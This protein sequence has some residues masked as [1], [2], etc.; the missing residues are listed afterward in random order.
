MKL[1]IIGLGFVGSAV[2]YG[3]S[4]PKVSKQLIDPK[5]GTSI[6]DIDYD[7]DLIFIC[8][9]TPMD[10]FSIFRETM[11]KLS[12]L[13]L[14]GNKFY[15]KSKL[16]MDCLI[17]IKSTVPPDIIR[18]VGPK[19]PFKVPRYVYNPEFLTE[20]SAN[21]Q[22]INPPFHI[23]GGDKKDIDV[24]EKY[25]IDYSLCNPCPSYKLSLEEASLVKYTINSFL[26][27]KVIFFNEIYG[28]CEELNLNFNSVINAVG[29]DPRIGHSHT[30]VPGFDNKK[31]F[32]GACFPKDIKALLT[33][34]GKDKLSILDQV[35]KTN[36]KIRSDYNLSNREK[37]QGIKFI[38]PNVAH[39]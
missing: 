29:S 27:T 17:A 28:L 24:L 6:E 31:G 39:T 2:D 33:R 20:R 11:E 7:T 36:D 22:F 38:K 30:K 8:V 14:D 23:F 12:D 18:E 1:A 19:H 9:P 35:I 34:F 21:E 32:G 5:L 37:E 26:A 13:L 10:D 3:F 4:N 15:K 25:Y 16:K